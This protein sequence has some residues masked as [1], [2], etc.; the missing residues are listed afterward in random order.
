MKLGF[1]TLS[2]PLIADASLRLGIPLRLAPTG[3]APIAR[4][5][6]VAGRAI[7]VRH[8]GSVDVFLEAIEGAAAGDVLVVDN[9]G[10][11]DEGCVGDLTALEA[12]AAGLAGIVIWGVHRDTAELEEIDFPLFSY[13][14]CPAG[15]QRGAAAQ[16]G[17]AA[18]SA[19]EGAGAR[20][21]R[22]STDPV[23]FGELTFEKSS[24]VFGDSDGV[25]FVDEDVVSEVM[26]VAATIR[27]T[28]RRQA[29]LIREGRSLR[30]QLR[31]ADYLHAREAD[32]AFTFRQHLR[33][34]GGAI[35]E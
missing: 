26:R 18:A 11:R 23:R 6:R 20:S 15:P 7:P 32:P 8:H 14:R 33:G 4:H 16:S 12:Q 21:G 30:T 17:A 28:E 2:T 25:L 22:R 13:G 34:I 31:F 29:A 5:H 9:D 35:E 27:D 10:R 1:E 24:V 19:A 3:I